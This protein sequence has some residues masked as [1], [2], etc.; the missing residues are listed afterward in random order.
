[1]LFN[2]CLPK[3]LV[4]VRIIYACYNFIHVI[5]IYKILHFILGGCILQTLFI[6]GTRFLEI[7][8][9]YCI[10]KSL[11]NHDNTA[12]KTVL[13]KSKQGGWV[14]CVCIKN[15]DPAHNPFDIIVHLLEEE[16]E[17][18]QK[19]NIFSKPIGVSI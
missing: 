18:F 1:M 2:F 14:M 6:H 11:M 3:T 17:K 13:N 16:I 4:E 9:H 15:S 5:S 10:S 8:I 19:Y 12:V 7:S